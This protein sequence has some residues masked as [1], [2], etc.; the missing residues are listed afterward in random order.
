M[1][2]GQTFEALKAGR[3]EEKQAFTWSG[4]KHGKASP[5]NGSLCALR[6]IRCRE[7]RTLRGLLIHGQHPKS[8]AGGPDGSPVADAVHDGARL[9]LLELLC[10]RIRYLRQA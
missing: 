6:P 1:A 7:Q 5:P 8:H 9:R 2:S 10:L 4:N 3:I